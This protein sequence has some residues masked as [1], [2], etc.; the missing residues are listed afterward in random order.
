MLELQVVGRP[1]ARTD[2]PAK[3]SGRAEYTADVALPGTVWGQVLRS[4][5]AHARVISIEAGQARALPGVHAVLTAHDLPDPGRLVGRRLRDF[6]ILALDRVLFIGQPVAAVAAESLD[7]AE[8]ALELIEVEY[9]ELP[10]V[11]DPAEALTPEATVLHPRLAEYV[12]LSSDRPADAPA[13][14]QGIWSRATGDVEAGFAEADVIVEGTYSTPPVHQGYLEPHAVLAQAQPDGSIDMWLSNKTP[15]AARG[16]LAAA[17]DVRAESVRVHPAAIGGDFG[18]KGS[19]MVAPIAAL[20]SRACGRPVRM[21]MSYVEELMAGNPRHAARIRLRAGARR[22]GTLTA[23]EAEMVLDGG[24][25]A[26]FKPAPT[27]IVGGI[28]RIAGPYRIPNV[29]LEGRVAYTNTVPRGHMRA[30]GEPQ[31][32]F[33]RELHLDVVARRLGIDPLELRRRNLLAEG[34]EQ[35]AGGRWTHPTASIVIDRAA[36][37]VGWG[38]RREPNVGRGL[39]V[40]ER[41]IGTGHSTAIL[42][43]ET[44]GSA[45]LLT[46]LFDTGTGAH[47]MMQQVAAEELGLDPSRVRVRI[48]GTDEAEDDSGAGGSRVTHVAGQAAYQAAASAAQQLTQLAAELYGWPESDVLL[49]DGKVGPRDR[50]D[51]EAVPIEEALTRLG[52][53]IEARGTYDTDERYPENSFAAQA[54]EVEV[55]PE[56]GQVRVRRLVS[57][58]D[59]GTVIN[60]IAHDGQIEGGAIQALGF[61]LMEEVTISPDEGRVATL[62]LGEYKLP[63]VGD[64]PPFET[65]HIPGGRGP[66]PYGGKAIG[67]ASSSALAPAIAAA[68]LDAV[69][70][71]VG[72]LPITAE[73][74]RA[75]LASVPRE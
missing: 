56:T 70:V 14:L 24:A 49:K 16:Q 67:E 65:L 8:A 51:E 45:E 2:G 33:A 17:L 42:W 75:G 11:F 47:T 69:G 10:P 53:P 7:V 68:V 44:D 27:H 30:P 60:P 57:V 71:V 13:N 66:A 31:A 1:I 73:K 15:F 58:H 74:V 64:A 36:E 55:D 34:E 48:G 23:L 46:G 50:F 72:D 4:P 18:G 19:L 9:E 28:A 59:V 54:A 41:G 12:G 26:A 20:L 21:V 37:A 52:E 62:S 38:A 39:A 5:V 40:S 6:P 25:Y 61:A 35:P 29:R 43:L 63:T 22:D 3:V 32:V